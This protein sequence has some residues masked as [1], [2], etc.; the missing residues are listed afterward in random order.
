MLIQINC[1]PDS[2]S[3]L[4]FP[5][6]ESIQTKIQ[7]FSGINKF[8]DKTLKETLLYALNQ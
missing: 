8:P 6:S 4:C 7:I 5:K 3:L 2:F 1:N